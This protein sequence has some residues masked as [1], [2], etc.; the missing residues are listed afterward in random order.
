METVTSMLSIILSFVCVGLLAV[1]VKLYKDKNNIQNKLDELLGDKEA[2]LYGKSKFSELGLMSAG[3]AHEISNPLSVILGRTMQLKRYYRDPARQKEMAEGLDS[4]SKNADRISQILKELRHYIYRDSSNDFEEN[5]IPVKEVIDNVLLF[6]GQR[7]KNHGIE[8]QLINL[9]DLHVKGHR[10]QLEQAILNLISNSFDAI[11]H[12]PEK[13][14]QISGV[15]MGDVVDLYF[16]DSGSG[17]P[18]EIRSKMMQPFFTTKKEKGTGLGL[19]LAKGIAEKHG[20][21]LVYIDNAPNTTFLFE[22]PN[23]A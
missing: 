10:G 13:W 3:I 14:I 22:L 15:K 6:C 8:L 7:L 23:A 12:L 1:C 21:D 11:D 9:D 5:F 20:G 19:P 18:L 16:K 4:I 17:I 2:D